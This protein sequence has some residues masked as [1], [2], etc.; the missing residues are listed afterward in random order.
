MASSPARTRTLRLVDPEPAP[1]P[2]PISVDVGQ[3]NPPTGLTDGASKTENGDGSVTIDLSPSSSPAS[4]EKGGFYENLALKIDGGELGRIASE[5]LDAI[6][7]DDQSRRE[8]LDTRARGI[9]LLG[10]KLDEPRGDVGTSGA[11]LEGM[12]TV[13]HPLLLESTLRFHANARG[14]LLPAAGPVKVR[15]D[16]PTKPF[17][18]PPP[19]PPPPMAPPQGAAPPPP[20]PGLGHNGGPPLQGPAGAGPG[21]GPMPGMAA[22]PAPGPSPMPPPMP[23]PPPPVPEFNNLEELASALETDMNHYLTAVATE[24]YPDTDR[25]LFWVGAGGQGIKKVYNCPIRQ[26]PVSES[27]DAEDIIVSNAATNLENCGRI[28]H[29]IR[30]R[31]STLKRMQIIGAYRDVNIGSAMQ[32]PMLD[33]VER[34]KA[35]IQGVKPVAA[36]PDDADHEIYETYCELNIQGYEHKY[37]KGKVSGLQC[38]YKVTIH[39]ESRQVLEIRRNW[40]EDDELCR[41]KQFFVDFPFV[42]A[43]GFYGIGLIHIVGNTTNTLTASWREMLDAGMFA[44]FP[45]FI[46]SKPAGRQ[47][48][49]QFRVPPGGGIPMDIGTGRLQDS[50]MPLPYKEP[51]PAFTAFIQ[52]VEEVGQRVAGTAEIQISEGNAEVPVGTT[53]AMI[54]Q[55]TKVMDAVHKRLHA[56]Q[57]H[58]FKLLKERF[59]EDPESFWRHNKK[60]T[61][62]W[63][64]EQFL[65]ALE[66]NDMVPVADP[67]NPTSLHRIAKATAIKALQ[68][69]NPQLYDA[70]A[71]DKRIMRIVGIDP[72]GLFLPAPSPDKPDPQMLAVQQ[73]AD[74]QKQQATL[75]HMDA[76]IKAATAAEQMKNAEAERQSR[77]KIEQMKIRL[78][79]MR[80][81]EEQIIHAQDAQREREKLQAHLQADAMKTHQEL[82]A[83][84]VKAVHEVVTDHAKHQHELHKS[85]AEHQINLEQQRQQHQS[86]IQQA[87]QKH[88]QDLEHARALNEEKVKAA[89]AMAKA[90]P[91][92][93]KTKS[94]G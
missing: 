49:N 37:K 15:N 43:M 67:N 5:L 71:V 92:T 9:T 86:E 64:K 8:W 91:K 36:K 93:P 94:N 77:E 2:G 70:M 28:T 27:V 52:H 74:A 35:E 87:Q 14:E 88:E 30:M 16:T 79:Q 50:V 90:K 84:G 25:M 40:P 10:L 72:E 29:R 20:P 26:R 48:T 75:A 11:P 83:S 34:K 51:G 65:A 23:A 54:E 12:S 81:Q 6:Q 41:P 39:K 69:A 68:A 73:K 32:Y 60:P 17:T 85:H 53:M 31:P 7:I 33:V 42:R 55:A 19:P 3:E 21:P 22:G 78:E 56:A 45:G 80:I 18:P 66:N 82:Q 47:L 76:A 57:A 38:P 46:Y 59:K 13:R 89:R 63:R 24:Y 58:E 61:I 62:P 1:L 4:Q 44:S